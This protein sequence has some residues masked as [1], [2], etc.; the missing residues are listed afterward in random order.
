LFRIW[1]RRV[2]GNFSFFGLLTVNVRLDTL[3]RSFDF[4]RRNKSINGGG[5]IEFFYQDFKAEVEEAFIPGN[6][7]IT[8]ALFLT[9][10]IN[11][12]ST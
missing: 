1:K 4:L 11:L 6:E 7:V 5:G 3:H 9:E 2:S 8:P 12:S 10:A